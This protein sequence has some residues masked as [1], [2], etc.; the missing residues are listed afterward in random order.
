MPSFDKFNWITDTLIINGH[1]KCT[2]DNKTAKWTIEII[3][4]SRGKEFDSLK[5]ILFYLNPELSDRV[6]Y[7]TNCRLSYCYV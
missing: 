7:R 3:A 5:N 6:C 4:K 2:W 1:L